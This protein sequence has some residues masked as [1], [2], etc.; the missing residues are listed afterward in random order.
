[1]AF[2]NAIPHKEECK[3]SS[4]SQEPV[5]VLQDCE[6]EDETIKEVFE[7]KSE[8]YRT[9]QQPCEQMVRPMLLP[10]CNSLCALG[11]TQTIIRVLSASKVLFFQCAPF[12]LK[13]TGGD[14]RK[15]RK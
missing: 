7:L 11:L 15:S 1:M 12:I 3:G 10:F 13:E 8:L 5:D 14:R 9:Q 4:G 2:Y 6:K